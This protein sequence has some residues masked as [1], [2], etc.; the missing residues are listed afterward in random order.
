VQF[1]FPVDLSARY[2]H[3]VGHMH[4]VLLSNLATIFERGSSTLV[5]E[6]G[7]CADCIL[8]SLGN[9]IFVKAP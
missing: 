1:R 4:R 8:H 6:F 7:F 9:R 5:M 2:G 3:W